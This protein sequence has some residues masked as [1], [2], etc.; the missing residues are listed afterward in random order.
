MDRS[1]SGI[2]LSVLMSTCNRAA[3][4]P[5]AIESVLAQKG[6]DFELIIVDD[7]ST[8]QT[9]E[10]LA[11]WTRDERV[12]SVRNVKNLG[13]PA[14]LNRAAS[15]ANGAFLARIDDDDYWTDE[16]KLRQ[17]LAWMDSHPEDVLLG[18]AYIDERGRAS[19]NPLSDNEIRRQMLFRCPFCHSSVMMRRTAFE[20][21]SG[22]DETLPY[23]ED[24]DL[25]FRL[26]KQGGMANL[27]AVTLVKE[28]GE[29][30]LSQQF[31]H[32]QLAMAQDFAGRYASDY[33]RAGRAAMVHRFN[34]LFFQVIP[35]NSALHRG[36]GSVF[37]KL[38]QLDSSD[39]N[40][41]T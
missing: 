37:R 1:G 27:S 16:H 20:K 31:F 8:D 35:V 23:A 17:Q 30:N 38:F 5:R 4:L 22:Y 2:R 39:R 34:R 15:L 41:K 13:L 21:V 7:H 12:C 29:N 24:W 10:I 9:P 3:T 33:P 25:W 19:A 32:R 11:E 36:M 18:T 40:G 28:P 14:S 26:G 6:A